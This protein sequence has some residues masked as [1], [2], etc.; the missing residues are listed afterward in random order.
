MISMKT[1]RRTPALEILQA[2]RHIQMRNTADAG[3]IEQR[4]GLSSAQFTCLQVI[5]ERD[6]VTQVELEH[7]AAVS[8]STVVGLPDRLEAKGLVR[9]KRDAEDRRRI[10]LHATDAGREAVRQVPAGPQQRVGRAIWLLPG[11][12]QE[13]AAAALTHPVALL[14]SDVSDPAIPSATHHP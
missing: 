3:F 13:A 8:P 11:P 5:A 14:D 4:L 12:E 6:Q 7:W 2:L 1:I 9:R 10:H